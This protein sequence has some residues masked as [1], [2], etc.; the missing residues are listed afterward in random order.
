MHDDDPWIDPHIL[1]A[2]N[3]RHDGEAHMVSMGGNMGNPWRSSKLMGAGELTDR[4]IE[5]YRELGF[6]SEEYRTARRERMKRK[7]T[8]VGNFI[9][10]NDGKLIYCP[11]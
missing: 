10:S 7:S 8:R 4:K 3:A 5:K 1:A 11:T 6:Y 2:A 9:K